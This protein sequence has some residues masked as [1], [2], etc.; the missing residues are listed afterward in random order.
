MKKSMPAAAVFCIFF[1]ISCSENKNTSIEREDLFTFEIGRLEDELDMFNL[2][3]ARSIRKTALKMRDGLF[4]ISNGNGEKIARYNSYGDLLFLIY[5]EETNPPPLTLREKTEGAAVTRWAYKWPLNEPGSIT[6][7]SAK[8][9]FV[10][11]RLIPER[12]VFDREQKTVL[13]RLV[14]HFDADGQFVDYLGQEGRGGTPFPRIENI[15]TSVD[16]DIVVVCQLPNG[17]KIFWYDSSGN[18]IYDIYF[19]NDTLPVPSDRFG[20]TPSLDSIGIAPD[21]RKIYLKIDYYREI[22][23]ESTNTISGRESDRS[24][25]WMVNAGGNS[26]S[27]SID[28]PFFETSQTVNNHKTIENLLYSM[29]GV[30]NGGRVFLYYPIE[31]GFSLLILAADGTK[32]QRRGIINVAGDELLYCAFDVSDDGILSALL[33]SNY[34]VKL[35]WWRTDKL[36]REMDALPSAP[37]LSSAGGIIQNRY[38]PLMN[39]LHSPFPQFSGILKIMEHQTHNQIVSATPKKN[40]AVT[41]N[42]IPIP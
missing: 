16:D 17:R 6:V 4:Y 21:E 41:L 35:V 15:F 23:D 26:F 32:E 27:G 12:H 8:H 20:L 33:S 25:L 2:E 38:A 18:Q 40:P 10:E 29:F 14:L 3:G 39:R 31:T 36:A 22:M 1:I 34:E 19:S 7:N 11:D 37:A 30:M 42:L 24:C 28:I 9:I 13:D 5:N